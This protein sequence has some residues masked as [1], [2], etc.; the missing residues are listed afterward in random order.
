M[1]QSKNYKKAEELKSEHNARMI[2][3]ATDY[4]EKRDKEL[5]AVPLTDTARRQEITDKWTQKLLESNKASEVR[6]RSELKDI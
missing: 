4:A 2:F 1:S 5:Q 6:Y 3:Y